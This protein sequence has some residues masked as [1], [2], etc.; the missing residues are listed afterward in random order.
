MDQ[1]D[2]ALSYE[3]Q[4][5]FM[6][7]KVEYLFPLGITPFMRAKYKE[8]AVFRWNIYQKTAGDKKLFHLG[9]SQEL[10]PRRLYGYI[11]PGPTQQTNKK[12]KTMLEGHRRDGLN[13]GLD[14]CLI[15]E[16]KLG[17]DVLGRQALGDRYIRQLVLAAMTVEL[18]K[19]GFTLLEI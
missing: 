14:I 2:I 16:L 15:H 3:W 17:G 19:K 8:P 9:E 12:V 10:C 4:P 7:D 5:V 1:L 11:S 13:A 6:R 18:R